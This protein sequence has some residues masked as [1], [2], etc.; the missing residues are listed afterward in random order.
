MG[1]WHY[2][3]QVIPEGDL[4]GDQLVGQVVILLL[5]PH[6]GLLE[7]A[8]LPLHTQ[9]LVSSDLFRQQLH[10]THVLAR[11]ETQQSDQEF[12][13]HRFPWPDVL[14]HIMLIL[15]FLL[16]SISGVL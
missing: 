14:Q 12:S 4:T 3:I 1:A 5:Q 8:V 7:P 9:R 11:Y 10:T 13:S 15:K 6:A 16:K 2:L